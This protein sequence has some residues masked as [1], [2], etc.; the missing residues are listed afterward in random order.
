MWCCVAWQV[1]FQL[2]G[3]VVWAQFGN[4][5]TLLKL[6]LSVPAGLK[7]HISCLGVLVD[8]HSLESHRRILQIND[9][10]GFQWLGI[11]SSKSQYVVG[12]FTEKAELI[13]ARTERGW[14]EKYNLVLH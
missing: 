12:C 13:L 7:S 8:L 10:P 1:A 14:K 3:S 11:G 4:F 6:F 9:V 2:V 5:F